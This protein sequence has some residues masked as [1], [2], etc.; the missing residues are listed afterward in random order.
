[1]SN[2][3]QPRHQKPEKGSLSYLIASDRSCFTRVEDWEL[4]QLER[5]DCFVL[6]VSPTDS[7]TKM[8][9]PLDGCVEYL[10]NEL[11]ADDVPSKKESCARALF[12]NLVKAVKPAFQP[13]NSLH[14][15][16]DG[17]P[18][19]RTPSAILFR[20]TTDPRPI[21]AFLDKV[22]L[23]QHRYKV[24]N[25]L[26]RKDGYDKTQRM[27]KL[28]FD[29]YYAGILIAMAQESSQYTTD[30][31]IK[32]NLFSPDHEFLI[33]NSIECPRE[34]LRKFSEPRKRINCRLTITRTAI[35][36]DSPHLIIQV[37]QDIHKDSKINT[38]QVYKS[39]GGEAE[40]PSQ[41]QQSPLS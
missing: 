3:K 41:P 8:L 21:F 34:Y 19:I 33:Q 25:R 36:F 40:N 4:K 29:P 38:D 27:R 24:F 17:R 28:E 10:T 32:A 12:R 7:T 18:I 30:D 1:M 26:R 39:A 6:P 31:I 5:L 2:H 35:P 20:S 37:L 23:T 14:L 11:W 9:F 16:F 22:W 13:E 15:Y